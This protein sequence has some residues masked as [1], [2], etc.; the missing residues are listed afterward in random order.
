VRGLHRSL[1][2]AALAA[3]LGASMARAESATTKERAHLRRGPSG[4]SELLAELPPGTALDV[5]GESGG[6]KQVRARDGKTGYVWAEHLAEAET[7]EALRTAP[8]S[9]ADE[10][11]DLHQEVSALAQ[12]P[13]PASAADLER[14]RRELERLSAAERDL[15]RRLDE[16]LVG[17]PAPADPAP[18]WTFW[19]VA[20]LLAL[21]AAIG[22]FADR[23]LQRR[24]DGR[25]RSRLRL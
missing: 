21:G 13:E 23:L 11:H 4:A 7:P 12:R 6:W 15:A 24:R 17:G 8:R 10:V 18:E 1:V 9:L 16:R 14:V 5:L 22:L 3:L 25:Q 19:A 2:G 20:A